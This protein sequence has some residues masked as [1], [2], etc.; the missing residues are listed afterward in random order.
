VVVGSGFG[1]LFAVRALR[2]APVDVTLL[3][4]TTQHLFQPL[5]YQVATGILSPGEVAPVTREVLQRQHNATVLLGDV[6][7]VDLDRRT[8]VSQSLAGALV[9]P[10]DHLVVAAGSSQS[11]FGDEEFARLAPGLKSIDD[12]LEVRGRI[13]G[14]FELAERVPVGALRDRLMTFVVVGAGPTGVE[15]AGQIAELAQRALPRQ[16]RRIDT[17][18]S[19][20]VLVDAAHAVL[21]GMPSRLSGAAERRLRRLGVEVLLGAPVVSMD[22][23]SVTVV[24]GAGSRT[25]PAATKVW[26]AGVSASPLAALLA[27]R[28]G[29]SVDAAGRVAVEPDL[30]LP[31]HPEVFVVGDMAATGLPGVAQVAIQ[32]GRYAAEQIDRS[33]R[34]LPGRRPFHYR[35]KGTLATVSRFSAVAWVGRL[36]VTGFVAWLLW[37]AVHLFYLIGF[38]NRVSTLMHWAVTFVGGSRAERAVT[39]QQVL[40]RVALQR[41][42]ERG[43]SVDGVENVESVDDPRDGRPAQPA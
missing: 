39:S 35:D 7:D 40:G 10:Y 5:L 25:I 33:V 32:G 2:R 18:R 27:D 36:Q 16:F 9:T 29:A 12:A 13:F 4:R 21:P 28:A 31:G 14:A 26:A 37:L 17:R 30:S 8:V 24:T 43:L 15:M 6:V 20:I 3:A 11:Y 34:C 19:R 38:K 42:E 23:R 22:E 1:G 41:L